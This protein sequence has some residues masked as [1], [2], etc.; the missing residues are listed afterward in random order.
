VGFLA[1]GFVIGNYRKLQQWIYEFCYQLGM[2]LK[3]R[4]RW[5]YPSSLQKS[6]LKEPNP[7]EDSL[8][9]EG[10][11]IGWIFNSGRLF[12]LLVENNIVKTN[13]SKAGEAPFSI[14]LTRGP[15]ALGNP[16]E[17]TLTPGILI[18]LPER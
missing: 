10:S 2:H 1:V 12:R 4:N 7:K 11:S 3:F 16:E 18:G 14:Y 13:C 9:F 17:V 5:R 8:L 6:R 15:R